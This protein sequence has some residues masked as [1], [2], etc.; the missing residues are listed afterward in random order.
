[1]P[2]MIRTLAFILLTAC[3]F[4]VSAKTQPVFEYSLPNGL[5]I[6]IKEDHRAP[7][8]IAQL[9]YK[10]GSSYEP[11]GTTGI[12]HALEHMMFRGTKKYEHMALDKI[13]IENGG[14][15]N[16]FTS[17]DF[18]CYH[19]LLPSNKL[20]IIFDIEADRMRNLLLDS[21]GFTEEMQIVMEER[22]MRTEDSPEGQTQERFMAAAFVSNPYRTPVIGW[23]HDIKNLTVTDLKHWYQNW[24]APN[25]A[26]L[27]V[28]GDVQ[29][30]KVLQ[31][32][33]QYFGKLPPAKL[34]EIKLQKEVTTLGKRNLVVKVPAEVPLIMMGYNVPSLK[35]VD[36]K[37]KAYALEVISAILSAGDSSRL[38]KELIRKKQIAASA[39]AYYG[40]YNRL[41]SIFVFSVIPTAK[42]TTK[43]LETAILT[44]VKK[45]QTTLVSEKELQQI[46][47]QII[48]HETYKKDFIA[49]QAEELGMLE[50]IGLPW[51]LAEQYAANITAIIPKQ[52]QEVAKEFFIADNLT[53]AE[54]HPQ[55]ISNKKK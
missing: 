2:I 55:P 38:P 3:S 13:I 25:N 22:K 17:Q 20:H 23:M 39:D 41:D 29:P 21:K 28:V 48:S 5:K 52:I 47:N 44:E 35:T 26:I 7:I 11:T 10:V 46:K 18:T 33:K 49:A 14:V 36:Q 54:L 51:Q 50:A 37:W 31:M 42:H 19:E 24:Y 9:C 32:A 53:V 4:I 30:E 45:L 12:S 43:D 1:M 27:V 40:L 15:H 8:A 16:A 6:L 34:V